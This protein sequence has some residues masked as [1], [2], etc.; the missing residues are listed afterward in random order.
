M[1]VILQNTQLGCGCCWAPL[2]CAPNGHG[3]DAERDGYFDALLRLP[4]TIASRWPGVIRTFLCD[5]ALPIARRVSLLDTFRV[6]KRPV[7]ELRLWNLPVLAISADILRIRSPLE[8][9]NEEATDQLR[10]R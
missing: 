2:D 10:Q 4:P 7:A 8:N 3:A 6:T 1:E 9:V 5:S